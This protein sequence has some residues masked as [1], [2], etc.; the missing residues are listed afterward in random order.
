MDVFWIIIFLVLV[1]IELITVNLVTIWFAIGAIASFAV[2]YLTDSI[3]IQV[4]VF[5]VVSTV[6]LLATRGI[7]NKV[8]ANKFEAT[9]LDRVIGKIGIVTEE[10]TKLEPG[11]VKV[12]GKKWSAISSKKLSIGSKVEILSI[13][14]VKLKVKEVKEE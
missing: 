8:K 5:I 11:E 9:N 13:E 12:D 6:S 3:T 4:L 14:G 10:I 2:T 7:I 1:F